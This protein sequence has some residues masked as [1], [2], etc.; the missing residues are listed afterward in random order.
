MPLEVAISADFQK[1]MVRQHASSL[2]DFSPATAPP[3]VPLWLDSAFMRYAPSNALAV[4]QSV[5]QALNPNQIAR[6]IV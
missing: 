6:H 4:P 1:S 5:P 3:E 2:G